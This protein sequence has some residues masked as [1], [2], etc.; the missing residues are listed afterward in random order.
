MNRIFLF[1]VLFIQAAVAQNTL[2]LK[3]CQ[4]EAIK[5]Y[6]TFKDKSL[7]KSINDLTIQSIKNL[8]L[9]KIDMNGQATYQS[10][11]THIPNIR[12]PNT[13][14]EINM[15]QLQKD[16]YKLTLDVSQTIYDGGAIS[17]Q[18]MLQETTLAVDSQQVEV[19]LNQL[20]SQVNDIYF[21]ILM[22]QNN[23]KLIESMKQTINDNIKTVESGVRNGTLLISNLDVL[24]VELLKVNE[25]MAEI[26]Y[27]ISSSYKILG[28]LIN[29]ELSQNTTLLMPDYELKIDNNY[30]RPEFILFNLQK[31]K[32]DNTIK[33]TS[34]D[35]M[36]KLFG[37][38]QAGYGRPGLNMLS[39][40]FNS[41]Y[42]IGAGLKWN[43]WDWR[44]IS[45][46][47]Q[48]YSIQKDLVE[49][50]KEAFDKT[51]AI[52]MEKELSEIKKYDELIEKDK[53]IITLRNNITKTAASQ[54]EHG[55]ITSTDYLTELNA[56]IQSKINLETHKI[57]SVQAKINYLTLKG[58]L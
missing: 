52:S 33:L 58:D 18:K 14:I 31:N 46:D 29:K 57:Q 12:I 48:I 56:E 3:D 4:Q 55:V 36:P 53:E 19:D 15:P 7:Y 13:P 42:Y 44:K 34:T 16:M 5:N 50:K 35:R 22:M 39:N 2:S 41:F 23:E 26:D 8:W 43:V 49:T 17:R 10:D 11:V 37:F 1:F 24:K 20:K 51:L 28:M 47:K 32:I 30:K 6:P 38:G 54:L 25:Q 21:S 9:P 40:N 45:H 27:N